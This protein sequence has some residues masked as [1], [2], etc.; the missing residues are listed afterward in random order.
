MT[1]RCDAPVSD[2][3]LLDYWIQAMPEMDAGQIEEHLFSCGECTARLDAMAS[4]GAGLASLARLGRVSGI[5]SR[6]LLNRLQ[7]DGVHVRMYSASPGERVPCAAFPGDDLLV[8]S[9]RVDFAGSEMVT[10]SVTGPEDVLI[11]QVSDVPV[12]PTDVEILWATPGERIRRM[13]STR[14]RLR[15]TSRG[16]GGAVLSEYQLDHTALPAG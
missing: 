10:V 13:P 9:M 16:S 8:V 11:G 15:I 6:A 4:L 5:V 7:R 1:P 12:A 14:V 2:A 3:D